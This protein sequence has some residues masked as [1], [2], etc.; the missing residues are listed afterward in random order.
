MIVFCAKMKFYLLVQKNIHFNLIILLLHYFPYSIRM[1]EWAVN[2]CPIKFMWE[3]WELTRV[4]S[5][6]SLFLI[7][8]HTNEYSFVQTRVRTNTD[9]VVSKKCVYVVL[10]QMELRY[11][12][13]NVVWWWG[14][15]I[16]SYFSQIS[17]KTHASFYRLRSYILNI[18]K[19]EGLNRG[20]RVF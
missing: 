15:S 11:L 2:V 10:T 6:N 1:T 19:F 9:D 17:S 3:N 20:K 5:L 7:H 4:F 12:K 8:T 13:E 16:F 14:N 18:L